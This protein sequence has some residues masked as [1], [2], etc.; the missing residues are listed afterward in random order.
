MSAGLG[1]AG[2]LWLWSVVAELGP[3][4]PQTLRPGPGSIVIMTSGGR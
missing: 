4:A 3:G 1:G 2:L